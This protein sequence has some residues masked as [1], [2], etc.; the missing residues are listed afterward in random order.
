MDIG[1]G[2]DGLK[3]NRR[4]HFQAVLLVISAD[5]YAPPHLG[6]KKVEGKVMVRVKNL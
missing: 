3:P 6:S 1:D 5:F 2:M 4:L